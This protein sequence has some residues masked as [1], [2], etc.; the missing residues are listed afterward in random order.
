M[1]RVLVVDDDAELCELLTEYLETEG[2]SVDAVR[3]G[4]TGLERATSDEY[5]L[6]VLDVMLPGLNGF[7][8]LRQLRAVSAVPVVMLTARGEEVDRIVGLE[9][10][11]D[12]YLPKPFNPRELAARIRAIQRRMSGGDATGTGPAPADLVRVGDVEIDPGARTVRRG[13]ER[14]EMTTAEFDVLETLLQAAGSVVS[15]DLLARKVLGRE[16]Y[17]TDRSID[18]HV[19]RIRKKLGPRADGIE[20]IKGIR[21]VGYLFVRPSGESPDA[22][23]WNIL[24]EFYHFITVIKIH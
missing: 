23:A 22:A 11:A 9:M 6:V 7:E 20:R 12:D 24:N 1:D 14:I 19:S 3:D 2:F 21:G 15:R 4:S 13:S 18:M 16:Y 5:G 8:V 10:G 17:V